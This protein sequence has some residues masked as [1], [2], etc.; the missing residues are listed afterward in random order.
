[1]ISGLFLFFKGRELNNAAQNY[2]HSD[3]EVRKENKI[4]DMR[5][6]IDAGFNRFL[7]LFKKSGILKRRR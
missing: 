5:L 3:W 4:K 2:T 7:A 1:L 6:S